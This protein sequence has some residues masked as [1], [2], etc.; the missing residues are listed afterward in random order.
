MYRKKKCPV[1]MNPRTVHMHLADH[2]AVGDRSIL[3]AYVPT[4]SDRLKSVTQKGGGEP[5]SPSPRVFISSFFQDFL[6]LLFPVVF[7]Y[8]PSPPF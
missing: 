4:P 7:L 1:Q 3:V 8:V 6:R 2:R 5:S